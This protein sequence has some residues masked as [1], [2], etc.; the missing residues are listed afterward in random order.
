MKVDKEKLDRILS[1]PDK[2]LWAEILKLSQAYGI[3]LPC[4]T[5]SKEN[6]D[7]LRSTA[8]G[9]NVNMRDAMKVLSAIRKGDGHGK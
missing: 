7:M 3:S 2:A 1:L 9:N 5:P 6:L 4:E 8:K